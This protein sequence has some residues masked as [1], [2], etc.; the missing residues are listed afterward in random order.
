MAAPIDRQIQYYW[1]FFGPGL[2]PVG[3]TPNPADP[4][5]PNM[6]GDLVPGLIHVRLFS[7]PFHGVL[8][9]GHLCIRPATEGL[10]GGREEDGGLMR[11]ITMTTTIVA[12]LLIASAGAHAQ[13]CT[14]NHELYRIVPE[15]RGIMLDGGA[16]KRAIYTASEKD[17]RLSTWKPGHNITYCPDDDKMINTTINS[18]M[19]LISEFTTSCKPDSVSYEIDAWLQRAWEAAHQQYGHPKLSLDQAKFKL[20]WY[21]VVCT[22]HS[23]AWFAKDDLKGFLIVADSLVRIN[24]AI[25]D[26]AHASTY[27][28]RAAKYKTWSNALYAAESKKSLP[29]RVWQQFFAP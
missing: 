29:Q 19:T 15:Y 4:K 6:F 10:R 17:E 16:I 13:E 3:N 21:Y 2:P 9:Q 1:G 18:V 22:D 20:G 11:A 25:D 28:A 8:V 26:P 12:V 7:A 14:R 27:E 24:F 5:N 23:D